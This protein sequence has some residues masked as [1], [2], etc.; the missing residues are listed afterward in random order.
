MLISLCCLRKPREASDRNLDSTPF[1]SQTA[2]GAHD[3]NVH[4][5]IPGY[6]PCE[7]IEETGL[8][9]KCRSAIQELLFRIAQ[10]EKF[11]N[12]PYAPVQPQAH[13]QFYLLP[14]EGKARREEP[15]H[16]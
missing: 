16:Q 7:S 15:P 9:A 4:F 11:A 8:I 1:R 13:K 6:K 10:L 12:G 14:Q 3:S 5:V 2:L